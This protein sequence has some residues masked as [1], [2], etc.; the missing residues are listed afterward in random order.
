MDKLELPSERKS[1]FL[2]IFE[3]VTQTPTGTEGSSS[4]EID[5]DP[6]NRFRIGKLIN[7]S[8]E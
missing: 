7:V 3:K 4:E 5:D 1:G 8:M 2:T 6:T